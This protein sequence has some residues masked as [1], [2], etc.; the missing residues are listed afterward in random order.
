MRRY[1]YDA[2]YIKLRTVS[3][4]YNVS[5]S[6]LKKTPFSSARIS[7]VGRNLYTFLQNTPK[8]L[9]PEATTNTGNGQGIEQGFSLP[10]ANFGFD[11]K[12]AF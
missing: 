2:S 10:Q 6:F 3:F 9:D 8:G 11:I 12:V 4:G 5:K 7:A 1:I